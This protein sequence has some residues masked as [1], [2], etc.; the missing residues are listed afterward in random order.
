M[1]ASRA[2]PLDGRVMDGV[3]FS[4]SPCVRCLCPGPGERPEECHTTEQRQRTFS[5][6]LHT[7]LGAGLVGG[8]GCAVRPPGADGSLEVGSLGGGGVVPDLQ[9]R[10]LNSNVRVKYKCRRSVTQESPHSEMMRIAN[11]HWALLRKRAWFQVRDTSHGLT[12]LIRM[13]IL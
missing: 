9:T 3:V 2:A 1:P 10:K 13:I 12:Y 11:L 4:G 5:G 8:A 7:Q 6:Q